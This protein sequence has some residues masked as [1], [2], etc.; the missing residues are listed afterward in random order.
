MKQIILLF[1]AL[2]ISFNSFSQSKADYI[3]IMVEGGK[4]LIGTVDS[5]NGIVMEN[6]FN[7]NNQAI[8][9]VIKLTKKE[10][11]DI[12]RDYQSKQN[13]ISADKQQGSNGIGMMAS[14]H[15]II[16]K[17]NYYYNQRVIKSITLMPND[18]GY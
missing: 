17:Y 6:V 15:K 3:N 8:V 13:L 10:T 5:V 14:K 1:F 9:Y 18:W 16:V 4:T 2:F 11:A 7:E 12:F